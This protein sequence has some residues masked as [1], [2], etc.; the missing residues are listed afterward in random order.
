[1]AGPAVGIGGALVLSELTKTTFYGQ[2]FARSGMRTGLLFGVDASDPRLLVG[3]CL[4]VLTVAALAGWIP[5][6]RATQID[7]AETLRVE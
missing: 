3:A 2:Q 7:P 6:R 5:V 4:L 1:M